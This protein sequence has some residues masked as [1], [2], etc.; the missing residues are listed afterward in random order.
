MVESGC[1]PF[2]IYLG[3]PGCESES[4]GYL[5]AESAP[6]GLLWQLFRARCLVAWAKPEP[7]LGPN[8]C[9]FALLGGES[10]SLH[11][12]KLP[13]TFLLTPRVSMCFLEDPGKISLPVYLALFSGV[14]A[15]L[16]L[17]YAVTDSKDLAVRIKLEILLM[18][19]PVKQ[20][21]ASAV[22]MG[23]KL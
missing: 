13:D 21:I 3:K 10:L 8:N 17:F 11:A 1:R 23:V 12:G 5:G 9:V 20:A 15:T 7:G 19:Q 4:G 6:F 18:V 16:A 22:L 2:S 14:E